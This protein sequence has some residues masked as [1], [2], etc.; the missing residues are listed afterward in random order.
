[1]SYQLD[2]VIISRSTTNQFWLHS[3]VGA[4]AQSISNLMT[5]SNSGYTYV[6]D[7]SENDKDMCI[8]MVALN[9]QLKVNL[10][11]SKDLK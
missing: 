3:E 8:I 2:R 5:S 9:V 4:K 6:F 1:M 10:E 7:G 11:E